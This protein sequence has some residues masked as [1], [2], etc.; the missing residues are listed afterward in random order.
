[1]FE[2]REGASVNS[3]DIDHRA[4]IDAEHLRLLAIFHFVAAGFSFLGVALFSMY[5]FL[6]QALLA[7]PQI[8][9]QSQEGPPPEQVMAFFR[10]FLVMFL[11][12]FL[13]S[14][15]GN[16]LSGLFMRDRR[17]RTF[18]MVIA[19]INC[20]HIPIGTT[21]GIFTF[22]VLGRESVRKLYRP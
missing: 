11:L 20:L 14:A 1:L 18:S 21:L 13:V 8:W 2:P 9:A 5:F 4:I 16:L 17:H 3:T 6:F 7:N 12:W 15:V 22:I 10:G 19:G